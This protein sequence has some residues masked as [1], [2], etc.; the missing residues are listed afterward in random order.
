MPNS[1]TTT[2]AARE[3]VGGTKHTRTWDAFGLFTSYERGLNIRVVSLERLFFH[4]RAL[5]LS[6][7]E[8]TDLFVSNLFR[9][10]KN[11]Q[12]RARERP[13]REPSGENAGSDDGVGVLHGFEEEGCE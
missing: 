4:L 5:S 9:T 3:C 10:E 13:S 12:V 7:G 11:S 8:S 1:T 6:E 2:R